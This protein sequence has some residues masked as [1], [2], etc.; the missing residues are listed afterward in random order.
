MA[1]STHPPPRQPDRAFPVAAFAGPRPAPRSRRWSIAAAALLLAAAV[2]VL[3]VRLAWS[4]PTVDAAEYARLAPAA[5]AGRGFGQHRREADAYDALLGLVGEPDPAAAAAGDPAP[6]GLAAGRRVSAAAGGLLVVLAGGFAWRV[7]AAGTRRRGA[8]GPP[9]S[10]AEGHPRAAAAV[11]ASLAVA[12]TG[13]CLPLVHFSGLLSPVM[14]ANA[15]LLAAAALAWHAAAGPPG[16]SLGPPAAAGAAALTLA[17]CSLSPTV[18]AAAAGLIAWAV[19]AVALR[20]RDQPDDHRRFRDAVT[21][22][23]LLLLV[24]TAGL[25][26]HYAAAGSPFAELLREPP[27]VPDGVLGEGPLRL[28]AERLGW[29]LPAAAASLALLLR[30]RP[31]AGLLLAAIAAA[32]L[33]GASVGGSGAEA[34]LVPAYWAALLGLAIGAGV[35]LPWVHRHAAGFFQAVAERLGMYAA[36]PAVG[37]TLATLALAALVVWGGYRSPAYYLTAAVLRDG[38]ERGP[39]ARMDFAAAA[40]ALRAVLREGDAVATSA[41]DA[42]RL[43][44]G[45]A[46]VLLSRGR[47]AA[48]IA[49]ADAGAGVATPAEGSDAGFALIDPASGLP[50]VGS[51]EGLRSLLRERPSGLLIVER[52]EWMEPGGL[53]LPVAREIEERAIRVALP[54]RSG[55]Y[56]FRW[57]EPV[58]TAAA[59]AEA[60]G[61]D[62]PMGT[63]LPGPAASEEGPAAAF[64]SNR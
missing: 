37:R 12:G 51:V 55:L 38:V 61:P 16:R 31:A 54:T 58:E 39:Y 59:P 49:L 4:N 46:D 62:R 47:L 63:L 10:G 32:A 43:H 21:S 27:F 14:A 52:I 53:P 15:A 28:L 57:S 40:P 24:L 22:V 7:V 41:P 5:E 2:P 34:E 36:A 56:A 17:A 20:L 35:L 26:L 29:V 8:G 30:A 33:L 25:A 60:P 50:V 6:R 13:L 3:A 44:L 23:L 19:P 42:T 48:A 9:G 11:A 18:A 45:R 1:S 64:P